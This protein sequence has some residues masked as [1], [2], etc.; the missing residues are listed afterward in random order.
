[1]AAMSV[2]SMVPCEKKSFLMRAGADMRGLRV[3]QAGSVHWTFLARSD[4]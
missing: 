3:V 2:H 1:M 4:A